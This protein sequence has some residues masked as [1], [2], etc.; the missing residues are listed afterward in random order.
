MLKL[1]SVI[2]LKLNINIK[3]VI[4]FI[5]W[6]PAVEVTHTKILQKNKKRT[7]KYLQTMNHRKKDPKICIIQPNLMSEINTII[8]IAQ[9]IAEGWFKFKMISLVGYIF[10][11]F[12]VKTL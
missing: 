8:M 11:K 6:A 2:I 7:L 12:K 10:S 4:L 5:K 3:E 1:N 9:N